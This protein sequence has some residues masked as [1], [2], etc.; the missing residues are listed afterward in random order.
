MERPSLDC[1]RTPHDPRTKRD[2]CLPRLSL[3]KRQLETT[4]SQLC[5]GFISTTEM[6]TA[7]SPVT[8]E[9]G[10]AFDVGTI[11]K[12]AIDRYETATG[13]KFTSLASAHN[14]NDILNEIHERETKFKSSRH[15]G[16][17]ID[18]FRTLV[19]KSLKPIDRMGDAVAQAQQK[20]RPA[21]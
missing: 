15:D 20:R 21:R 1:W 12:A 9:G 16:S 13:T 11:W 18:K 5:F 4:S 7:E 17:K 6:T 8:L 14:V 19:S 10:D 3:Y 2:E